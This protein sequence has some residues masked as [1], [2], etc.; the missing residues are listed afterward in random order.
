MDCGWIICLGFF[1]VSSIH[2]WIRKNLA[3]NANGT[4]EQKLPGLASSLSLF[5]QVEKQPLST[6]CVAGMAGLGDFLLPQILSP[7]TASL[8]FQGKEAI[9]SYG[10]EEVELPRPEFTWSISWLFKRD[11]KRFLEN[12]FFFSWWN[13]TFKMYCAATGPKSHIWMSETE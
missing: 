7:N 9:A 5:V 3:L 1:R 2:T 4:R 8:L 12:L 11:H 10:F 6:H 13:L